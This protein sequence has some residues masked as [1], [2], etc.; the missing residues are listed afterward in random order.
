[1]GWWTSIVGV[2][3]VFHFSKHIKGDEKINSSA[4]II[5]Q[6]DKW[7]ALVMLSS[8]T[9]IPHMCYTHNT[10]VLQFTPHNYYVLQSDHI[11]YVLPLYHIVIMCYIQIIMCY[12]YST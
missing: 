7:M 10:Y 1:M 8:V 3:L 12:P 11:L 5:L 4:S 9:L 6:A 2:S